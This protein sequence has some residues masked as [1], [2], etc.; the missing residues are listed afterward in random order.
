MGRAHDAE[1]SVGDGRDL[2]DL[3][4]FGC[5]HDRGID[6]AEREVVVFGDE[7][8]DAQQIGGVNRFEREGARGEIAEESDFRAPAQPVRDQVGDLRKDERWDD[9][10]AGVSFQQ[11]KARGVVGVITIDIGIERAGVDDQCDEATS[12]RMI[13]SIR[14]EMSL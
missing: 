12:A 5:C 3:E 1:V 6:G 13:S 10:W 8:G 7:L 11:L 4:S 14:S 2:G 9:Q